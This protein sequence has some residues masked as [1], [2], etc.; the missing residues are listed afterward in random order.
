MLVG[1]VTR[2][3]LRVFLQAHFC[4]CGDHAA[5]AGV[6]LNLLEIWNDRGRSMSRELSKLVQ[7]EGCQW[8]LLYLVDQHMGLVDHGT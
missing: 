3:E 1:T 7:D 2:Q 6:L 8:L 4:G 5:A